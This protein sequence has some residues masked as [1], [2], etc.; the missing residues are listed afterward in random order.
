MLTIRIPVVHCGLSL[1]L[2]FVLGKAQAESQIIISRPFELQIA[3]TI[4]PC[5][6]NSSRLHA[7]FPT[8]QVVVAG[9]TF[10][11]A[12]RVSPEERDQITKSIMLRAY[13]G[14]LDHVTDEVLELVREGWQNR[15]YMNA[16]VDGESELLSS[17]AVSSRIAVEVTIEEG[18]QYRLGGITFRH[19]K[20][21]TNVEALRELFPIKDGDLANR[22]EIAKGMENLR[23][24]YEIQGYINATFVPEPRFDGGEQV[25]SF[26]IDVDEDKQFSV[27]SIN[28]I[29][30]DA[31][32][33]EAARNDLILRPGQVY[34]RNYINLFE[35]KHPSES[36]SNSATM[37][38][39]NEYQGTVDI[40]LDLRGCDAVSP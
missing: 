21:I 40:T 29:G 18:Q 5:S 37:L 9:L 33:L 11:G 14:S 30:E 32:S 16:R 25:V 10:E 4:E 23:K 39:V 3:T 38:H 12:V 15:G 28:L 13:S 27:N 6:D 19:N 22:E 24:A 1:A 31:N 17:T 7:N 34:N 8:P 2:L 35:M 20:V 26:D 36:V